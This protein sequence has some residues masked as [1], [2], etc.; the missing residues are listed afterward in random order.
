MGR[1]WG[2]WG[3]GGEGTRW[4][5]E[6]SLTPLASVFPRG[7]APARRSTGVFAGETCLFGWLRLRISH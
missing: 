2:M 1:A 4:P 3:R 7:V 5:G 6:A